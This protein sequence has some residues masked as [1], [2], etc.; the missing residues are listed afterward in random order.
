MYAVV[1]CLA[2]VVVGIDAGWRPLPEGGV[3]YLIQI[4]PHMLESLSSGELNEVISSHLPPRVQDVRAFRISVGNEELPRLLPEPRLP[5]P[6][7]ATPSAE[8]RSFSPEPDDK[9]IEAQ[10]ANFENVTEANPTETAEPDEESAE[11]PADPAPEESE[12]DRPW[13]ALTLTVCALATS[14]GGNIYLG[15]LTRDARRR[16]RTLLGS[17]SSS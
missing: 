6:G 10:Q 15:M 13:L 2:T 16:C 7:L 9:P 5:D 14:L 11:E 17:A 3:E 4:E 1:A 12:N 8:P